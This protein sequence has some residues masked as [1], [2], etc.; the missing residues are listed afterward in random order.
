MKGTK[1]WQQSIAFVIFALVF[2]SMNAMEVTAAD[3]N[4]ISFGNSEDVEGTQKCETIQIRK[5]G[6]KLSWPQH[7]W[8][9]VEGVPVTQMG[10][11]WIQG[12]E[13][14]SY[15]AWI[16][17]ATSQ[18]MRVTIRSFPDPINYPEGSYNAFTLSAGENV[19]VS[20]NNAVPGYHFISMITPTGDLDGMIR[21]R[22][23][24]SEL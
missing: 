8:L 6:E 14:E 18:T 19:S 7:S 12:R 22:E 3:E 16:Y 11:F 13:S 9:P 20:V 2:W 24:M 21:V 1:K 4:C 23:A 10:A 15:R 17:N 5:P